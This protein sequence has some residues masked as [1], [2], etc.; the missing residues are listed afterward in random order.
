MGSFRSSIKSRHSGRGLGVHGAP[1]AHVDIHRTGA[2]RFDRGR[3]GHPCDT[4]VQTLLQNRQD[5]MVKPARVIVHQ[6]GQPLVTGVRIQSR[7]MRPLSGNGADDGR[8][9]GAGVTAI[10]R[11]LLADLRILVSER[12]M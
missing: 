3:L 2:R 12:R 9:A 11:S 1:P 7:V 8:G 5:L 10:P 4:I 6:L